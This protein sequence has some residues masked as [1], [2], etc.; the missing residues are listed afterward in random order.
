MAF[1]FLSPEAKRREDTWCPTHS[2]LSSSGAHNSKSASTVFFFLASSSVYALPLSLDPTPIR[3]RIVCVCIYICVC[4]AAV[5]RGTAV[6]FFVLLCA[7]L[8]VFSISA[9]YFSELTSSLQRHAR[10]RCVGWP[11]GRSSCCYC[12]I[13]LL[14]P[15]DHLGVAPIQSY[16][17]RGRVLYVAARRHRARRARA[18]V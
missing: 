12:S 15:P 17:R 3:R 10:F 16:R 14:R 11:L 2:F 1:S 7:C 4:V 13:A 8:R 6:F 18:S 9:F 5:Q